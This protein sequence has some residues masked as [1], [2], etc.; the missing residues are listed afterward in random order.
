MSS[1][2]LSWCTV[3]PNNDMQMFCSSHDCTFKMSASFW[4]MKGFF[5]P[6][7]KSKLALQHCVSACNSSSAVLKRQLVLVED[8]RLWEVLVR[9]GCDGTRITSV[10]I[11]SFI[12]GKVR[13]ALF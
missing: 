11:E 2:Q 12:G 9:F 5:A 4:E 13:I 1:L 7:S 10:A 3:P 6:S 8:T